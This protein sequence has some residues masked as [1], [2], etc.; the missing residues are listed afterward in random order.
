MKNKVSIVCSVLFMLL[1]VTS[2]AKVSFNWSNTTVGS[3]QYW[4]NYP[5]ST[6]VAYSNAPSGAVNGYTV[7]TYI[8]GDA[9]IDFD[10]GSKI[11]ETYGSGTG[12]DT[13]LGATN[14]TFP[15]RL[16]TATYTVGADGAGPGSYVGSYAYCVLVAVTIDKFRN[17]YGGD[18]ALLPVG[19]LFGVCPASFKLDQY[20]IPPED[21]TPQSQSF[22]TTVRADIALVPEPSSFALLG[23]GLGLVGLRRLRK[24]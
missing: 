1:A 20:D 18:V 8:S 15:G 6:P 11:S 5:S 4:Y 2:H 12:T 19:T 16:M 10:T 9:G 13:L 3:A 7:L 24:K 21:G 17:V 23:I 22:K 14:L